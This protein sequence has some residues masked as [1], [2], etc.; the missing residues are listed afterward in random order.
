[1]LNI[2]FLHAKYFMHTKYFM[3]AKYC[4][5]ITKKS[6]EI[7]REFKYCCL[8]RRTDSILEFLGFQGMIPER[9]APQDPAD[10][11]EATEKLKGLQVTESNH[12]A[13]TEVSPP[14]QVSAPPPEPE[15]DYMDF[16]AEGIVSRANRDPS[17]SSRP[18]C[19]IVA[20]LVPLESAGRILLIPSRHDCDND[21]W[22]WHCY[23]NMASDIQIMCLAET[24][25]LKI[26]WTLGPLVNYLKYAGLVCFKR[27]ERRYRSSTDLMLPSH[28]PDQRTPGFML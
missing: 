26:P 19:F 17:I 1:M 10:M 6:Q 14:T 20:C 4:L 15:G 7:L 24:Y 22:V 11:D 23:F 5:L 28:M 12:V 27:S 25:W 9:Q 2:A 3:H 18:Y 21:Y 8:Y 13:S 16:F